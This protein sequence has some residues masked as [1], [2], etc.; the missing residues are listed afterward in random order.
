MN[1]VHCQTSEAITAG[2]GIDQIQSTTGP[3]SAPNSC[4]T[5]FRVPLSRP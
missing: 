2:I 4:Q 1:G 5:Q 3:S